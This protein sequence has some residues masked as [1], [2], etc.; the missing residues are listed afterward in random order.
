[1]VTNDGNHEI[2][3]AAMWNTGIWRYIE[4]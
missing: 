4:P 3:V 1:V 2:F